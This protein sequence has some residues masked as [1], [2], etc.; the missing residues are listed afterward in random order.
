MRTCVE[1]YLYISP[2]WDCSIPKYELDY[3][4]GVCDMRVYILNLTLIVYIL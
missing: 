3:I 1:S 2:Y 4:V